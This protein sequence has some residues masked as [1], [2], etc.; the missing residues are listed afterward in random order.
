M[1]S[2]V[3][4][5]RRGISWQPELKP[6]CEDVLTLWSSLANKQTNSYP[7]PPSSTNSTT[8]C[9]TSNTKHDRWSGRTVQHLVVFKSLFC[10]VLKDCMPQAQLLKHVEF[11]WTQNQCAVPGRLPTQVSF[12]T[13]Q[14]RRQW[15]GMGLIGLLVQAVKRTLERLE[16]LNRPSAMWGALLG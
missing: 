9:G 6:I 5:L 10:C 1:Q 12:G 16:T 13:H 4:R 2:E 7:P 14:P 3:L 8:I 11:I 15:T